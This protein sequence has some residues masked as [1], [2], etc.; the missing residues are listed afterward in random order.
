MCKYEILINRRNIPVQNLLSDE[1]KSLAFP[2]SLFSICL[3]LFFLPVCLGARFF[4]QSYDKCLDFMLRLSLWA[5]I[6]SVS[7]F[8][9]LRLD[10][11]RSK[12]AFV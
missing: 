5:L 8:F 4:V 6:L 10:P 3:I 9:P 12:S 1:K 11:E 7:T 2:S